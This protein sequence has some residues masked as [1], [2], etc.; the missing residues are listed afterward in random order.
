MKN[1][2]IVKRVGME[3]HKD[4]PN[5]FVGV[6]VDQRNGRSLCDCTCRRK[7]IRR[8]NMQECIVLRCKSPPFFIPFTAA[9]NGKQGGSSSMRCCICAPTPK[10]RKCN[11]P[12][13]VAVFSFRADLRS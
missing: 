10:R 8:R 4:L 1:Q 12:W 9:G 13:I 2:F 6:Q 11:L 5:I 3:I 7:A